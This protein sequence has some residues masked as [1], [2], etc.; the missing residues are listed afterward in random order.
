MHHLTKTFLKFLKE[1]F[2]D[3]IPIII[4]I[5]FF[6][7]VILQTVPP[8]WKETAMWL[9]IVAL[10]LAVFLMWLQYGI[11][12][13]WE[14]LTQSFTKKKWYFWIMFFGF[15][16]GFSTTIAEPALAVIAEKAA[17]ISSWKIDANTLRYVVA[18]SVWTAISMWIFRILKGI[19]IQY[20]IIIWY[21]LVVW[22]T[23]FTPKEIVGLAYDLGWVTTSTITVPLVTAIWIWITAM[24]R[25]KNPVINGFWLIAC[26]SLLPMFFVQVY[27]IIIYNFWDTVAVATQ[28]TKEAA[29]VMNHFNIKSIIFGLFDTIKDVLPIILTIFFFQYIILKESIPRKELKNI[30]W[31]FWMVILWLY[32]FILWLEM[33]LFNLWQEMANQ[34]TILDSHF[35]IYMFAFFIGFSTTMAE[36]TLIA[37]SNKASELDHWKINAFILRV[38]VALWVWIWITIWTY[39]IIYWDFIHYYIMVWYLFVIILTYFAPKH[40]TSIAYDSGWVTTSTI[41]VPLVAALWIW[42]AT[43]IPG[44][45]PLHDWFWLI[46]FASLF[47]IISVLIYGIITKYFKINIRKQF[48]E[49]MTHD[50][51]KIED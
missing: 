42:L 26:A 14:K 11:F 5:L 22:I 4:V 39:R 24:A 13:I 1:S 44:R 2:R 15:L 47:P 32:F 43:N 10:W 21:L 9:F 48:K 38:F 40:I 34:L 12:P 51:P 35:I 23:Y 16:V 46:A 33:W 18:L 37:I 8:N 27:G 50:L 41:T 31:G 29:E 7:L 6:Q 28:V 30:L 45:D 20:P 17:I 36:P 19:P 49:G 25:K 3:L